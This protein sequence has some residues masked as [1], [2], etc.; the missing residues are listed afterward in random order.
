MLQI[1]KYLIV[2]LC[3][4]NTDVFANI[5]PII[6]YPSPGRYKSYLPANNCQL[7]IK[8]PTKISKKITSKNFKDLKQAYLDGIDKQLKQKKINVKFLSWLQTE[9]EIRQAFLT[10]IDPLYDDIPQA[11]HIL[12]ALY[13]KYPK[14]IK[15]YM[16][17]AI[18]I[19][20]VW[21]NQESITTSRFMS[22]WGFSV[23]QFPAHL[24]FLEVFAY[25]TSKTFLKLSV[26]KPNE[27]RW[28]LLIYLVDYDIT[29]DETAWVL[30]NYSNKRG[31]LGS[32]YSDIKY[33]FQK[34]ITHKSNIGNRSYTLQN[35]KQYR[36]ICGDQSHFATR[37]A[38]TFG[39]PA[40]K[41]NGRGRY[42]GYHAWAGYLVV[43]KSIPLLQFTGRYRLDMY[44]TGQVFNPQTRYL[45]LDRS[46][47]QQFAAVSKK[48]DKYIDTLI[49][50]RIYKANIDN[51]D[52]CYALMTFALK[53]NVL[54]DYSWDMLKNEIDLGR[55][56]KQDALKKLNLAVKSLKKYPD[57]V[58]SV[59]K[60]IMNFIPK[61]AF[62]LRQKIYNNTFK[63]LS[64]RPDLQIKLLIKQS[65]ELANSGRAIKALNLAM[66]GCLHNV[67]DSVLILPLLQIAID[68]IDKYNLK[69]QAVPYVK[70]LNKKFPKRRF[71]SSSK[72][73]A[74]FLDIIKDY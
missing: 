5:Q 33:D 1:F 31:N 25:F 61:D 56:S 58:L 11:C 49:A 24:D 43:K 40:M 63:I 2:L 22:I 72:A 18:A 19:A 29:P 30:T 4:F 6:E 46:V 47:E 36:G 51:T 20:V 55:L 66:T 28:P 3:A 64:M 59:Q 68:I 38:K 32:A 15:K 14:K 73:Y 35:I 50:N 69:S 21:D 70:K 37:I 48:Y 45:I 52:L 23:K 7:N 27:L 12:F 8:L 9:P 39:V 34:I 10:A 67:K 17:L 44:Y 13:Q 57:E 16:H 41:V 71:G 54:S 62:K 65:Q 60:T 26:F 53:R 42:G 74:E